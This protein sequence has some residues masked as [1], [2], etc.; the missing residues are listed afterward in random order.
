MDKLFRLRSH[1]TFDTSENFT[2]V[3]PVNEERSCTVINISCIIII[4]IFP[5]WHISKLEA[6]LIKFISNIRIKVVLSII[7][8]WASIVLIP[9]IFSTLIHICETYTSILSKVS[10]GF[11]HTVIYYNSSHRKPKYKTLTN[12]CVCFS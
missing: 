9:S 8:G 3:V 2:N 4:I 12:A 7:T 10:V 11:N 6:L 5:T 1:D